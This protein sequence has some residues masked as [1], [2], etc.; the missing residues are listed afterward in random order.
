MRK[1]LS[2]KQQVIGGSAVLAL[3]AGLAVFTFASVKA[4]LASTEFIGE[5]PYLL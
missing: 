2:S 4:V 3:V 1:T 5:D